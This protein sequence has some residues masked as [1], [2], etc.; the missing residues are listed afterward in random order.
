[1]SDMP[2][3]ERRKNPARK[4][5]DLT[6]QVIWNPERRSFD[7]HRAGSPTG[8]FAQDKDVAVGLAVRDA[9]AEAQKAGRVAVY[10]TLNGKQQTE[11]TSWS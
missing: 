7:V 4:K 6:Y 9:Q 5:M 8:S 1:M 3:S 10:S 2:V 11:W